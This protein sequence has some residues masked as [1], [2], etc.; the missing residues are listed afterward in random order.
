MKTAPE[1]DRKFL[2]GPVSQKEKPRLISVE[3]HQFKLSKLLKK[4]KIRKL[5]IHFLRHLQSMIIFRIHKAGIR[6]Q[7]LRDIDWTLIV[8]K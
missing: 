7:R 2:K 4:E 5:K 1:L 3:R 8:K 6:S